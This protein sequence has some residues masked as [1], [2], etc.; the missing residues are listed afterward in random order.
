LENPGGAWAAAIVYAGLVAVSAATV[1]LRPEPSLVRG[2]HA[3]VFTVLYVAAAWAMLRS[4]ATAIPAPLMALA[5][6]A[7]VSTAALAPWWF[8]LGGPRAAV[9]STLEVCLGRVCAVYERTE[10]G[11]QMKVP[12][13]DMLISV[14][15]LPWTRV[16]VISLRSRPRHR[17]S[18]LLRRLFAKQYRGAFPTPRIRIG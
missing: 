13:G 7:V 9:V 1:L 12:T 18:D 3:F 10:A 11:F 14:R 2:R 15:A 6:A 17:K 5:G 4:S 8:V 16:T